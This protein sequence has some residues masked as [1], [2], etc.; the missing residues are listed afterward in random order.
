MAARYL[1]GSLPHEE[2]KR[3][4]AL[5]GSGVRADLVA[6]SDQRRLKSAKRR[7]ICSD[8]APVSIGGCDDLSIFP[9]VSGQR[10]VIV[11]TV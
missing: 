9:V 3:D 5:G 8:V 11:T 7:G 2:V 1:R 4:T 6:G 10:D